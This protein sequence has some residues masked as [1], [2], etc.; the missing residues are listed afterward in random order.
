MRRVASLLLVCASCVLAPTAPARSQDTRPPAPAS[1][2]VVS[3]LDG[4]WD[5]TLEA[6]ATRLRI[7]FHIRTTDGGTTATM[8]SVDQAAT[9]IPVSAV[10]RDGDAVK[11]EVAAIGGRFEGALQADGRTLRGRWIQAALDLPFTL[12]R[13][14]AGDAAPAVRRPQMPARPFPYREEDVAYDNVAAKA[15]LAATLTLPSGA[16]PFP[17]IVLIAGSGP[18][19]RDETLFAHKPFLVLADHLTRRGFAVLRADK[20]GVGKST[21]DYAS[22]TTADF[23]T[24]VEAAIAYLRTRPEIDGGRI[25]LIGH[26]E[27]GLIAPRIAAATP[28]AFIVL[29]AGPGTRGDDILLTQSRLLSQAAG[30][31]ER[32]IEQALAVNRALFAA[33]RDTADRSEAAARA[34]AILV[35]M[36]KPL[37]MSDATIEEAVQKVTSAWFHYFLRYDPVPVLRQVKSPVLAIN[38]SKDLQVAARGEP[39]GD[40]RRARR[41][42]RRRDGR[43][44]R[45]QSLVP[46]RQDRRRLRIRRDRGDDRAIGARSDLTVG[47][48][49]LAPRRR[50][51][52]QRFLQANQFV[53][54]V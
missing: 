4:E 7:V 40:P 28:L 51:V 11:L 8:D 34:R 12:T 42:W 16:G 37:G 48:R 32:E 49:A 13:R 35:E 24:D 31:A 21:G 46:D 20:R 27:G 6:G 41:Q 26:S 14:E 30:M 23:T 19:D 18:L 44:A 33:V 3:G 38:G 9:G 2:P 47:R 36:G 22:A 45:A 52:T 1:V 5:G 43:I 53:V 25:G 10:S 54:S 17:A 39:G 29:M 15:R 50:A